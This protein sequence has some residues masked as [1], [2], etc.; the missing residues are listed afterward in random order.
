[1]VCKIFNVKGLCPL[2]VVILLFLSS[3]LP[4]AERDQKN[5]EDVYSVLDPRGIWPRIERI[6]LSPRLLSL[7]GKRIYII[8]SWGSGTGFETVFSK[9]SE[10]I[11][12]RQ[13]HDA[14]LAYV[15]TH[16][17]FH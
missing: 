4:A 6:P 2:I 8:N 15:Q 3:S 9:I 10:V 7:K 5:R 13:P 11:R 14:G 16:N 17:R 12:E 1:M